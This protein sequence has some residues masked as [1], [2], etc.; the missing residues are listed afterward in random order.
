MA[1]MSGF[2]MP[3]FKLSLK[4]INE[5]TSIGINESSILYKL[6]NKYLSA[7]LRKLQPHPYLLRTS[8]YKKFSASVGITDKELLKQELLKDYLPENR[9]AFALKLRAIKPIF[10]KNRLVVRVIGFLALMAS[11]GVV[12]PPLALIICIAICSFTYFE[13]LNIGR[14]LHQ[15]EQL[16]YHWYR[17]KIGYDLEG[18]VEVFIPAILP[19][20][21]VA[22][23]L[24]AS[25]IFDTFGDQHGHRIAIVPALFMVLVPGCIWLT[26][27]VDWSTIRAYLLGKK[28]SENIRVRP[29]SMM[30]AVELQQ[31]IVANP[32]NDESHDGSSQ[33]DDS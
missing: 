32:L 18:L 17:Q 25:L 33:I 1:L 28:P 22:S 30:M 27:R 16:G 14:I 8:D 10:D 6:M 5:N 29:H 20:T 31:G 13:Q 3:A 15:S 4:F 11:F 12:F 2:V 24:F 21:F 7:V 19:M 23:L 26:V 9:E